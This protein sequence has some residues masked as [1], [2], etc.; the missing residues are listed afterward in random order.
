MMALICI[1]NNVEL[2]RTYW[3]W[4]DF[5]KRVNITFN[6]TGLLRKL[7]HYKFRAQVFVAQYAIAD[8][9]QENV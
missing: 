6:R 1:I 8:W 9:T 2:N 7:A 4:K 5:E 3:N